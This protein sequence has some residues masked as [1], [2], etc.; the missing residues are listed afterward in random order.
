MAIGGVSRRGQWQHAP[1]LFPDTVLP[2]ILLLDKEREDQ[3][4]RTSKFHNEIGGPSR[5]RV[6]VSFRV[7]VRVGLGL[8]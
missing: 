6:R 4:K 5:V 2:G 1:S 7:R 3:V 8:G